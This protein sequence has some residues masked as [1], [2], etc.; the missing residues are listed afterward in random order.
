ML[1]RVKNLSCQIENVKI[2]LPSFWMGCV[3][4]NLTFCVGQHALKC[5]CPICLRA[6]RTFHVGQVRVKTNLPYCCIRH[7]KVCFQRY[8][9]LSPVNT[10]YDSR[11]LIEP[12]ANRRHHPAPT[13]TTTLASGELVSWNPTRRTSTWRN[14]SCQGRHQRALMLLPTA[15]TEEI[16]VM[17]KW[18]VY[19]ELFYVIYRKKDVASCR[20]YTKAETKTVCIYWHNRQNCNNTVSVSRN[21]K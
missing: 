1:A 21:T 5:I 18:D 6:F 10:L 14:K 8:Y 9:W 11:L 19:F 17:W 3:K 7:V 15:S 2:N 16:T 20:G 4:M 12:W 13:I